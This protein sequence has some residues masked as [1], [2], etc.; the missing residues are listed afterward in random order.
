M[1]F[2]TVTAKKVFGNKVLNLVLKS[3]KFGTK[4]SC[5]KS[6]W[7]KKLLKINPII[8]ILC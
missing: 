6:L 7:N 4:K 1:F 5:D 3:P 2:Y 8:F